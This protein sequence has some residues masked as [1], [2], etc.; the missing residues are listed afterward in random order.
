MA[1][2]TG[3]YM[4]GQP[5]AVG[6][7]VKWVP[8]EMKIKSAKAEHDHLAVTLSDL[9]CCLLVPRQMYILS[10]LRAL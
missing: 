9:D 4:V 2:E 3:G 6:G 1:E 5:D 7:L 10:V 8:V